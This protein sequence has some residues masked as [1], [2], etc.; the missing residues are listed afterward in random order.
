MIFLANNPS[1]FY[2]KKNVRIDI[3]SLFFYINSNL[4]QN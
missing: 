3:N 4:Y 1:P 2:K